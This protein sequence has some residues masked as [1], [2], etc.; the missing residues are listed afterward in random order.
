MA[1]A[2]SDSLGEYVVVSDNACGTPTVPS[3]KVAPAGVF[4]FAW[5]KRTIADQ[6]DEWDDSS[7]QPCGIARYRRTDRAARGRQTFGDVEYRD[8]VSVSVS[9]SAVLGRRGDHRLEP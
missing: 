5:R 6:E 3:S 2:A 1:D 4:P 9:V 8:R 7:R